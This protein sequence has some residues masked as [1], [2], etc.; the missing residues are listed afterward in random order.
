MGDFRQF[1]IKHQCRLTGI[2]LG[3]LEPTNMKESFL[4]ISRLK[5]RIDSMNMDIYKLYS[6]KD[7]EKKDAMSL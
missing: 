1:L 6:S 5:D 7:Y 4:L 3:K 2:D